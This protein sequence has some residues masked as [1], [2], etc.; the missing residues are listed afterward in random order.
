MHILYFTS[1]TLFVFRKHLNSSKSPD[2]DTLEISGYNLVRC[3]HP[4]NSK[5][6]G[7]CIYCKNYVPLRIITVNYLSECINFE[8]TVGNKICNFRTIQVLQ[9]EPK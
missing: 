9:S 4:F 5:R 1:S 2:D 8:I 3:D 6:A 7:A